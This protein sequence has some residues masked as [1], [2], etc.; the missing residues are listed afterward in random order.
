MNGWFDKWI[1]TTN[2]V[3]L[4]KY[5][6]LHSLFFIILSWVIINLHSFK[7]SWSLNNTCLNCA[8][9]L[10]SRIF[11]FCEYIPVFSICRSLNY[12]VWEKVCVSLEITVC[13]IKGTRVWV[14]ILS[15]PFQPPA[16]GW[17]IYHVLCFWGRDGST[18]I[19]FAIHSAYCCHSNLSNI[20]ICSCHSLKLKM[21]EWH[22]TSSGYSSILFS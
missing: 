21:D 6:Q 18:W 15:K 20:F 1:N 5:K 17:V 8:G 19:W 14:L 3:F 11:F 12:L 2:L 10:I 22:V 13:G 16:L 9:P 7:Y 4:N